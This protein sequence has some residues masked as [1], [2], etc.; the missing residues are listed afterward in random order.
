MDKGIKVSMTDKMISGLCLGDHK[1]L[2]MDF[3]MKLS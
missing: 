2:N 1:F 3:K